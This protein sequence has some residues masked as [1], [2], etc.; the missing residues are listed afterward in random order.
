MHA[1]HKYAEE[2]GVGVGTN[3]NLPNGMQ[4]VYKRED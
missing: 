3:K 1:Q 4:N 2:M